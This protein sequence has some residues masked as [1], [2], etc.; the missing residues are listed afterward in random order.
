[1]DAD[2]AQTFL[3]HSQ[4]ARSVVVPIQQTPPPPETI[5]PCA[6]ASGLVT[7]PV[8]ERVDSAPPW[9][10]RPCRELVNEFVHGA[11]LNDQA[12]WLA[13]TIASVMRLTGRNPQQI[14]PSTPLHRLLAQ[15]EPDATDPPDTP[16]PK[17]ATATILTNECPDVSGRA[18]I[19]QMERD[20]CL[21]DWLNQPYPVGRPTWLSYF[22][23]AGNRLLEWAQALGVPVLMRGWMP[24]SDTSAV[25]KY[26]LASHKLWRSVECWLTLS[27]CLGQ[28]PVIDAMAFHE[29]MACDRA[30]QCESRYS[31]LSP[32]WL[33]TCE[34]VWLARVRQHRTPRG[35]WLT[36]AHERAMIAL[37][38]R[39]ESIPQVCITAI[40]PGRVYI[41]MKGRQHEPALA[42]ACANHKA[43]LIMQEGIVIPESG[44]IPKDQEKAGFGLFT[45][46]DPKIWKQND[47]MVLESRVKGLTDNA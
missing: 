20:G 44:E 38:N 2:R 17:D 4:D 26:T 28:E 39:I 19:I 36:Q 11:S 12:Q 23:Q 32:A 33:L 29:A 25:T 8:N 1:M 45:K 5:Q 27:E 46:G 31:S 40:A 10:G 18:G 14:D 41:R 47:Q 42:S 24:E 34:G 22:E 21:R 3:V 43:Y 9:F 16:N 30:L 15:P 6:Q 35:F 13:S 37:V 7:D